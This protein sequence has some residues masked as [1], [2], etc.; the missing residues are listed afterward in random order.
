METGTKKFHLGDVLTITASCLVSPRG[1]EGAYDILNFMTG[2]NLFTHQL[3]RAA[4]ECRP[5]LLEQ[6]PQLNTPEMQTALGLLRTQSCLQKVFLDESEKKKALNEAVNTW[7]SDL[8]AGKYGV[9]CEEM[10][11]VKPLPRNAHTVKDPVEE[12]IEMKGGDPNKVVV[13]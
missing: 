3:P 9:K 1:M 2:D 10:L 5:Y 11:E 7:L 12:A 8:V 6:F 4:E 13:V